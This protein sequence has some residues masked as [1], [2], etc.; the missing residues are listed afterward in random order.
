MLDQQTIEKVR[1]YLNMFPD[2]NKKL[3]RALITVRREFSENLYAFKLC[4]NAYTAV[5]FEHFRNVYQTL[6]IISEKF[7]QY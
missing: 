3:Y 4:K 2:E 5:E 7:L 1:M 6:Y